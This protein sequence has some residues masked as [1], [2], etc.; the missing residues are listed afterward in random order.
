MTIWGEAA[1][2]PRIKPGTLGVSPA[3]PGGHKAF[4]SAGKADGIGARAGG[5][6]DREVNTGLKRESGD[7]RQAGP[8]RRAV[9]CAGAPPAASALHDL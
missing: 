5:A 6:P 4:L 8:A 3:L 2:P 7:A 1:W 9:R